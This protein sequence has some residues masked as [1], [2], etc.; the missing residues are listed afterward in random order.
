MKNNPTKFRFVI[1]AAGALSVAMALPGV[2]EAQLPP[3]VRAVDETAIGADNG[4]VLG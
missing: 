3:G 1:R 4:F 2:V